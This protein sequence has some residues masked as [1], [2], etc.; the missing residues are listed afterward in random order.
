MKTMARW[1]ALLLISVAAS[2]AADKRQEP[3]SPL[4][5]Y[6]EQAI[7]RDQVKG[8]ADGAGSL[9]SPEAPLGDL[10]RDPRAYRVDDLVT[11]VV[12]D[13]ASATSKGTTQTARKS[14]T[15]T[16]IGSLWGLAR[17]ELADLAQASNETTLDG[18]GTTSRE[19][20]LSTTLSAR[21]VHVLPNGNLVV[22]GTKETLVNSE[23]QLVTVRG[24]VRPIDLNPANLVRSDRLAMLE[25]RVNG[26][27]VVGD[28]I[29]RPMFLYRLLLGLLPF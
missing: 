6:V 11:I 5:Q 16:N 7:G 14:S 17:P 28:A 24:V 20:V 4:D 2:G 19:T 3:R 13:R 9:W 8:Q 29:R 1:M 27:G 22:E 18:Q 10:A 12:S 26:K 25:I 23:R 21:V 15:K